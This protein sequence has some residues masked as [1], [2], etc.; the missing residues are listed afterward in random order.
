MYNE[1]VVL[2]LVQSM[3][4]LIT[5]PPEVFKDQIHEH[6]RKNGEN[7]YQRIKSWMELSELN[8]SPEDK[9]TEIGEHQVKKKNVFPLKDN[10]FVFFSFL[11][12]P[13]A[14]PDFPL[15][16]ASKGFCLTLVSF[17]DGFH[18]KLKEIKAVS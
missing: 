14:K 13:I 12:Q 17:L 10:R 2:K 15:I 4:K 11:P 18:K 1:M 6:F 16:P 9:V 7:F 8:S 3:T 5:S